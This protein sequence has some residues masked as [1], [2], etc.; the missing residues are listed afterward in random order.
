M[1]RLAIV[2]RA[3]T[4]LHREQT[5]LTAVAGVAEAAANGARLVIFPEAFIPGYPAWIWRLRPGTDSALGGELHALLLKSSVCLKRGDLLPLTEAAREYQVTVVCGLNE[6][7]EE[8]GG[9]TL[10]NTVLVI[11]PEGT[12]LNR[13]RKLMPT[14]PER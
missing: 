3:P 14:N 8:F 13:H 7:D 12:I 4:L 5:L 1:P 9:G 2:Q 10:Y 6:R 11:G